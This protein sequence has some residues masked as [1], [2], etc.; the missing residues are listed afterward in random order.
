M[1]QRPAQPGDR[2]AQFFR[3]ESG[4]LSDRTFGVEHGIDVGR[5]A[6]AVVAEG[7]GGTADDVAANSRVETWRR[8]PSP[9][10]TTHWC[11]EQARR[12]W[13]SAKVTR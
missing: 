7:Y 9:S 3:H 5:E 12:V 10:R 2:E 8:T 11:S 13:P 6:S 4:L 1:R